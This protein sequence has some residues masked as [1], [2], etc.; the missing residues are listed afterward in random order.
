MMPDESVPSQA[1][2]PTTAAQPEAQSAPET[3][4]VRPQ[5][6]GKPGGLGA[7]KNHG[8]E[9]A[10]N[11]VMP[12]GPVSLGAKE[13]EPQHPSGPGQ[14]PD[15]KPGGL[16]APKNHETEPAANKVMPSGPVSLGAKEGEPQQPR[17]DYLQE[18]INLIDSE[19]SSNMVEN[20]DT[21]Q[22]NVKYGV[23]GSDISAKK[24]WRS[25]VPRLP[26]RSRQTLSYDEL[27]ARYVGLSSM[28]EDE[29]Y[30]RYKNRAL[31]GVKLLKKGRR[32][33]SSRVL[34]DIELRT[35]NPD[36]VVWVMSGVGWFTF[37]LL[38]IILIIIAL[39]F[40]YLYQY[41]TESWSS[42]FLPSLLKG[43][44]LGP[45]LLAGMAGSVGAVVSVLSR[46]SSFETTTGQSQRLLALTGMTLP[47]IGGVFGIFSAAVISSKLV[48]VINIQLLKPQGSSSTL[49]YSFYAVI[50][51]LS[52][53]SER[54]SGI[55]LHAVDRLTGTSD[56]DSRKGTTMRSTTSTNLDQAGPSQ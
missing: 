41:V 25:K 52:G 12:S 7:P 36:A 47:I 2:Q 9:P 26:W 31:L 54:F 50:G 5:P 42:E 27:V 23:A 19:N 46:L 29:K 28:L 37:Y 56:A 53:F 4:T 10:A 49:D 1:D 34:A 32:N 51:F 38:I 22:D 33:A 8:T 45:I 13:G 43:T 15:G 48:D 24:G 11:K 35:S 55:L 3:A 6:D 18:M 40:L 44:V 39:R 14:Q 30:K 20:Q 16:E 21:N 17:D